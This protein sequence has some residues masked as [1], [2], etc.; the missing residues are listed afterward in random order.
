MEKWAI[1]CKSFE[2]WMNDCATYIFKNTAW[3]CK[4]V[5]FSHLITRHANSIGNKMFKRE[6][7]SH[8]LYKNITLEYLHYI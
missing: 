7:I 8:I 2:F 4:I 6:A 1:I 3:Y 5:L